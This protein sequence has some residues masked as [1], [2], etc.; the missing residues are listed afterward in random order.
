MMLKY[1]F[2]RC[3]YSCEDTPV[4]IAA[5]VSKYSYNFPSFLTVGGVSAFTR[6]QIKAVNGWSNLFFGWGGEDDDM[7]NRYIGFVL[8]I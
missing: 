2:F 8:A 3:S 4:H 7:A 6:K 1:C 5:A